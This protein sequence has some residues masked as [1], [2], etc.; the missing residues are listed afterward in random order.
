MLLVAAQ[1]ELVEPSQ[2]FRARSL[3]EGPGRGR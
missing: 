2:V 3:D 1:E